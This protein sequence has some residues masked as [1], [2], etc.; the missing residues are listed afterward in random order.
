MSKAITGQSQEARD[1]CRILGIDVTGGVVGVDIS[2]RVGECVSVTV[3]KY[4]MIDGELK[5]VPQMFNLIP[6]EQKR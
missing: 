1:I 4:L 6:F 3:H 2:I 5:E